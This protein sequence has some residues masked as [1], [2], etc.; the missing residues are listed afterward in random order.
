MKNSNNIHHRP[1]Q[2]WEEFRCGVISVYPNPKMSRRSVVSTKSRKASPETKRYHIK[3]A[4]KK[5][6]SLVTKMQVFTKTLITLKMNKKAGLLKMSMKLILSTMAKQRKGQRNR[7]LSPRKAS[8][9]A[10]TKR[11][12]RPQIRLQIT[13]LQMMTSQILMTIYQSQT[14]K[15]A[16]VL[17]K[18]RMNTT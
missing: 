13:L 16:S 18:K 17:T 4:N 2:T 9:V 14:K 7:K 15:A 3:L 6:M 12:S 1:S 10:E 5:G 8:L 11:K